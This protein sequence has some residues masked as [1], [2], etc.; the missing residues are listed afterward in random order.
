MR[1]PIDFEAF[2][3]REHSRV[4]GVLC[5]VSGDRQ[6]AI[7]ATDEAF[8]RALDRWRSAWEAAGYEEVPDPERAAEELEH[9]GAAAG[10]PAEAARGRLQAAQQWSEACATMDRPIVLVEPESWLHDETLEAMLNT[11]PAGAEVV[12]V[13]PVRTGVADESSADDT[14]SGRE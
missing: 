10:L 9:L 12:I 8:V 2:Y 3:L 1:A 4:L 6:A 7:E 14:E 5:A 11:L 13:E